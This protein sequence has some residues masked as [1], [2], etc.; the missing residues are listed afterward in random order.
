MINPIV[1]ELEKRLAEYFAAYKCL[2]DAPSGVVQ[3]MKH[4]RFGSK[5]DNVTE[6]VVGKAMTVIAEIDPYIEGLSLSEYE[7]LSELYD[8][9]KPVKDQVERIANEKG[10][11]LRTVYRTRLEILEKLLKTMP[12]EVSES[13][14]V[15]IYEKRWR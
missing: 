12:R 10:L 2:S 4:T 8:T 15:A 14:K 13:E 11:T 5:P 3:K 7:L 9:D 1:Q 6:K